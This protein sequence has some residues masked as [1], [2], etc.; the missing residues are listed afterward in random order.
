MAPEPRAACVIRFGAFEV[1]LATHEL[2]RQGVKVRLQ[3]KPF[4]VLAA[5]VERPG[6]V[7][8]REQLR[9]RLWDDDTFVDVDPG[10]RP[11]VSRDYFVR[12]Q[13][14]RWRSTHVP[15]TLR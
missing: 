3:E 10:S 12:F 14:R 5:L 11:P 7:V 9:A 1:D 13:T 4:R 15:P 6:D 2:R 8:T